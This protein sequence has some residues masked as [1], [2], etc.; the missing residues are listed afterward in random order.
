MCVREREGEREREK[1]RQREIIEGITDI[2]R[3]DNVER[4]ESMVAGRYGSKQVW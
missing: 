2:G 4:V 1:E 3:G